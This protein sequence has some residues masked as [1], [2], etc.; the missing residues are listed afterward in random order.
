MQNNKAPEIESSLPDVKV[1]NTIPK[2]TAEGAVENSPE[3]KKA[4]KDAFYAGALGSFH[5]PTEAQFTV[6]DGGVPSKITTHETPTG[7]DAGIH[8]TVLSSD[9]AAVHTHPPLENYEQ[10]PSPA[11]IAAAKQL[12]KPIMVM[13]KDG[14]YEIDALGNV[15]QVFKG[16]NWMNK[17]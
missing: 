6:N 7:A 9:I 12:K 2:L 5:A 17:K 8:Q 15:R 1:G 14:L 4:A 11:D 10:T 3:F 16:T 13:S